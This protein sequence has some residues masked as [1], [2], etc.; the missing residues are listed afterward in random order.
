[1]KIALVESIKS[2]LSD[3]LLTALIV[4]LLLVCIGYCLFV[5]LSLR[6]S[7]L[8]V[9]IHY[10]AYG[11]TN[12]YRE[13]WYYLISFILFGLIVAVVHTTLTIKLYLQGRRQIALLFVGLSF[14][15]MIIASFLAWSVL[16]IAFL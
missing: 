7:D 3:R 8:Q 5:G 2:V 10:T 12:F 13:K 14:L 4:G 11:E 15:V 16:R 6:P 9:A 1:M